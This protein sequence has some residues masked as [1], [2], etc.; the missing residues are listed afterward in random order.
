M[1]SYDSFFAY[2][3][4]QLAGDQDSAMAQASIERTVLLDVN[5]AAVF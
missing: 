5:I 4:L 2:R 3:Q 1:T